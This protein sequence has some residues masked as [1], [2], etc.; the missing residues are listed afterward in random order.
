MLKNH[1]VMCS[2]V[3]SKAIRS[4]WGIESRLCHWIE[5][6]AKRSIEQVWAKE[7]CTADKSHLAQELSGEEWRRC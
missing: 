7:Y 2:E 1:P 5:T 3:Q 4:K 6:F